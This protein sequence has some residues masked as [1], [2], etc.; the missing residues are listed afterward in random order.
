[1]SRLGPGESSPCLTGD[2]TS[3]LRV[4]CIG[5]SVCAAYHYQSK[6]V[7]NA[8]WV[9]T[10]RDQGKSTIDLDR[11]GGDAPLPVILITPYLSTSLV[12]F[13]VIGYCW[14]W[15]PGPISNSNIWFFTLLTQLI[16]QLNMSTL[17]N[18]EINRLFSEERDF[19]LGLMSWEMRTV[20]S[21]LWNV[22]DQRS[23]S[24]SI[25]PEE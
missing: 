4:Q 20:K 16:F 1:M 17:P 3:L 25:D 15:L 12:Y 2:T 19:H 6:W 21:D 7:K 22:K 24:P 13:F 8:Y 5:P 10:T 11:V 9:T 18:L 14:S 23:N